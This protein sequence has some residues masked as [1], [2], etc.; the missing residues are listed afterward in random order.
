MS[1]QRDKVHIVNNALVMH[2]GLPGNYT[3]DAGDRIGNI[4]DQVWTLTVAYCF[5]LT[6]W[7]F[8]RRTDKL[9]LNSETPVNGW[10]YAFDLPGDRLGDPLKFL[11][12]TQDERPLRDFTIEGDKVYCDV[13]ALWCR[14]KVLRDPRDWDDGFADAFTTVL[15]ARLSVPLK[16]DFDLR[17]TLLVE[18]FGQRPD[19][20]SGGT[21]GRLIAHHRAA[22]PLAS[23]HYATDPLTDAHGGRAAIGSSWS[24][25]W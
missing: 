22:Q 19:E 18:A 6:D 23:P 14:C 3:T 20:L 24:G 1:Y 21:F 17:R 10:A 5:G 9:T 16:Q 7:S 11:I 13:D 25:R 8:C 4:V 12:D 15:A 2:L